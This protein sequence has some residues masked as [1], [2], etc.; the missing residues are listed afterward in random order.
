MK[1][2]HPFGLA[3]T[4]FRNALNVPFLQIDDDLTLQASASF[5]TRIGAFVEMLEMKR[6]LAQKR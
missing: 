3:A 2:C 1:Y 4:R 6:G 5:R